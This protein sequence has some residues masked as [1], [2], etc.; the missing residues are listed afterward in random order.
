MTIINIS[1]PDSMQ[2]FVDEQVKQKGYST[3]IE[4]IHHLIRQEQERAEHQR[5]E[6]MLLDGLDSGELI[7]VGEQWWNNKREGL[8][9]GLNQQ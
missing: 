3:A 4:Y 1:F 9:Q 5:L 7:E 8:I 6:T 2:T